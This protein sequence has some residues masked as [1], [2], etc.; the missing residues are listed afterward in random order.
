MVMKCLLIIKSTGCKLEFDFKNHTYQD[1]CCLH[2]INDKGNETME[3]KD[4][5]LFNAFRELIFADYAFENGFDSI[6]VR[7]INEYLRKVFEY[8]ENGGDDKIE[9]KRIL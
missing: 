4:N 5:Q 6:R 7:K 9:V 8:I 3:L 2:E 1:A